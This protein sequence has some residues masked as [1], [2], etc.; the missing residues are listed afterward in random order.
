[1][2]LGLFWFFTFF[3][4]SCFWVFYS[5][6]AVTPLPS[7]STK[8]NGRCGG[9]VIGWLL[10]VVC[11]LVVAQSASRTEKIYVLKN[12]IFFSTT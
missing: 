4:V 2:E 9:C 7:Y 6:V 1:M 10:Q 8:T 3:D 5:V 11:W 12:L